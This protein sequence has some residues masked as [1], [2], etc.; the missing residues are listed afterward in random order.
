MDL[1]NC[2][3]MDF[4]FVYLD[5][6]IGA[7]PRRVETWKTNCRQSEEKSIIVEAHTTILCREDLPHQFDIIFSSII[8]LSFFKMPK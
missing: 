4:P 3:D 8:L 1:L 5:I 7:N 6:P 2:K